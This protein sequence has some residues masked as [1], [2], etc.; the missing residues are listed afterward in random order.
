[1]IVDS[2]VLCKRQSKRGLT[3]GRTSGYDDKV[4]TL[5]SARLLVKLHI[6]CRNTCQSAVVGRRFLQNLHSLGNHG[7]H[8]NIVFLHVAL[9]QLEEATLS[10]LH[11][12]LHVNRIVKR[13]RLYDAGKRDKLPGKKFLCKNAGMILY[14]SRRSH[15]RAKFHNICGTSYRVERSLTL[16]LVCNGHNVYRMLVYVKRLYGCKNFLMTW[17]VEGLRTYDL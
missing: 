9:R 5:P 2:Y 3:H 8:L 13:L 17:F 7:V 11:K 12:F 10:F 14:V 1:M 16:Q 4:R 15:V 6:T